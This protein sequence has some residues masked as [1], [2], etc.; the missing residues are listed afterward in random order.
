MSRET[1]YWICQIAGWGLYAVVNT[2][3]MR[4]FGKWSED[5]IVTFIAISSAGI[6]ITHAMRRVFHLA[7]WVSIG[8][9]PLIFRVTLASLAGGALLTLL[10]I[11]VRIG[12]YQ[13]I[14]FSSLTPGVLLIN[15]FNLSV[16]VFVWMSLYIGVH[17]LENS[18]R[19]ELRAVQLTSS[20]KETELSSLKSQ[21]NPHFLFNSLNTIRALTIENPSKA[22][23]AV[24]KLS[25]ILRYTL[26]AGDSQTA[27]LQT[28]MQVVRDY[29]EIESLRFEERLHT[30]MELDPA[31]MDVPVPVL[32]VQTLVENAVKHG[33][34]RLTRGGRVEIRTSLDKDRMILTVENSGTWA[35]G[36]GGTQVGLANVRQRLKLIYGDDAALRI[37]TSTPDRVRVQLH[38]PVRG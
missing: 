19:N 20:L 37:D 7:R 35:N 17:Y 11:A 31:A 21:L 26:K 6:G 9:L 38:I 22:H 8:V 24:T 1:K 32:S 25:N 34:S 29:L 10:A 2:V 5:A 36:N 13:A 16:V 15:G 27:T 23:E 28:E 33:I 30:H 3:L 14:E 18:R 4:A 12:V